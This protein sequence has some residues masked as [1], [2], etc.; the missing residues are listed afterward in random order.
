MAFNL[1]R[2]PLLF[3]ASLLF[4]AC[5]PPP[6][7]AS[8]CMLEPP[9]GPFDLALTEPP[10]TPALRDLP[11]NP[12][13]ASTLI[14]P[15][16][17]HRWSSKHGLVESADGSLLLHGV[18]QA[19]GTDP[20][21]SIEVYVDY[22]PVKASIR[23]HTPN[24]NWDVDRVDGVSSTRAALLQPA[25]AFDIELP[26]LTTRSGHW[27]EVQTVVRMGARAADVRRWTLYSGPEPPRP[28]PC[29][30]GTAD[31][32][33]R[34]GRSALAD[35]VFQSQAPMPT[36]IAAVPSTPT[37]AP[38]FVRFEKAGDGWSTAIGSSQAVHVWESPF[39]GPSSTWISSFWSVTA[40]TDAAEE[41]D[42]R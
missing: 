25:A 10:K 17:R 23:I 1:T 21:I 36:T 26:P 12:G 37:A 9:R 24:R 11:V 4:G 3:G 19:F 38:K 28:V 22:R 30:L 39:G 29:V 35:G 7:A 6:P 2:T 27:R 5:D 16:R 32:A 13:A 20:V 31:L 40:H 18:A 41:P 34:S 42:L 8:S 14:V 15:A 33:L